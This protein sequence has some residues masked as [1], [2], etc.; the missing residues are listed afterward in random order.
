MS[1]N[2]NLAEL[3]TLQ[4]ILDDATRRI[5][6]VATR[7]GTTPDATIVSDLYGAERSLIAARRAIDRSIRSLA[8]VAAGETTSSR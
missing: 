3:S 2:S 1:T 4:T 5:E 8:L 7:L 6:Q